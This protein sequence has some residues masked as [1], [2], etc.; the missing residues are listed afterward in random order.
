[1]LVEAKEDP[2]PTPVMVPLAALMRINVKGGDVLLCD[3]VE[4]TQEEAVRIGKFLRCPI[5][6]ARPES[7]KVILKS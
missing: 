3:P 6:Y 1:M 5:I 2:K 4:L 7:V